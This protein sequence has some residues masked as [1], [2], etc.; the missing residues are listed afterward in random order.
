MIE[1]ILVVLLLLWLLGWGVG[2]AGSAIHF[3]LVII[4][5]IFAIDYFSGG[6]NI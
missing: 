3:L 5:V 1:T 4:I 6:R 2:F